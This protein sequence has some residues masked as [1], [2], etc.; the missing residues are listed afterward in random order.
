MPGMVRR[1]SGVYVVRL[2]SR[3]SCARSSPSGSFCS[4]GP[5]RVDRG[6]LLADW[7]LVLHDRNDRAAMDILQSTTDS[8]KLHLGG[9]L[10]LHEASVACGLAP[11]AYCAPPG[12]ARSV[13]SSTGLRPGILLQVID[14]DC[15][16]TE[17]L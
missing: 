10:P 14:L 12:S 8:P 15:P 5:A 13:C 17:Q 9:L 2:V 1:S 6:H 11:A 3:C 16:K 7:R 4:P